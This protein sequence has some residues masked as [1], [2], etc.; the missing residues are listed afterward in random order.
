MDG[1][2]RFPGGMNG[3]QNGQNP[4]HPLQQNFGG[5]PPQQPQPQHNMQLH[6]NLLM[7]AINNI[8]RGNLQTPGGPGNPPMLNVGGFLPQFPPPTLP[9]MA[10]L[11]MALNRSR[12]INFLRSAGDSPPEIG[13]PALAR[14]TAPGNQPGPSVPAPVPGFQLPAPSSVPPPVPAPQFSIRGLNLDLSPSNAVPSTSAPGTSLAIPDTQTTPPV[15]VEAWCQ[16]TLSGPSNCTNCYYRSYTF[17][18]H[19]LTFSEHCVT[20][21][22]AL[23][24]SIRN[25]DIYFSVFGGEKEKWAEQKR[26]LESKAET[27]RSELEATKRERDGW[28][29]KVDGLEGENQD[30]KEKM[31]ALEKKMKQMK[32]EQ[33]DKL[34]VEEE[35]KKTIETERDELQ[36]KVIGL[37]GET[38]NLKSCLTSKE[39]DLAAQ[40]A[41]H[42]SEIDK[43]NEEMVQMRTENQGQRTLMDSMKTRIGEL[44]RDNNQLI[45][46]RDQ[47]ATNHKDQLREKDEEIKRVREEAALKESNLTNELEIITSQC[48]ELLDRSERSKKE[49]D[50][51]RKVLEQER[52][53]EMEYLRKK[54]ERLEKE[55]TGLGTKAAVSDQEV[56]ALKGE[57][58]RLNS[59]MGRQKMDLTT[60]QEKAESLQR[61]V[62]NL[63][64]AIDGEINNLKETVRTRDETINNQKTEL[65]YIKKQ[66]EEMNEKMKKMEKDAEMFKEFGEQREFQLE[67]KKK[68]KH[69]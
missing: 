40:D 34:L 51:A 39:A 53:A 65:S 33:M 55:K 7:T 44:D 20:A 11:L 64:G 8:I 9:N 37:E 18:I 63:Q 50:A 27:T 29:Y 45:T 49:E 54:N 58:N 19:I 23:Q 60:A 13:I 47:T 67:K 68:R 52:E 61:D 31:A 26:E 5:F 16:T 35:A 17:S 10:P 43:K 12:G 6:Q 41:H 42:K 30:L 25:S 28:K 15:T 59:A 56:A 66:L 62:R 69:D 4:G 21:N 38:T 2:N 46:E 24:E 3:G 57:V 22:E 14:P 1:F 36:L 32:Q 48:T